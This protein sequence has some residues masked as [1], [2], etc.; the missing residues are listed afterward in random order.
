[1]AMTL[2]IH[3]IEAMCLIVDDFT[4]MADSLSVEESV[5][6]KHAFS[7][8]KGKVELALSMMTQQAIATLEG[9]PKEIDGVVYVPHDTGKWRPDQKRIRYEVSVKSC[10]DPNT[11]EVLEAQ[12]A[13]SRAVDIMYDLFVAP[14][15]KPKDAGLKKLG[16]AMKDVADWEVTGV[17]LREEVA[18]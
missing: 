3:D 12:Q 16:L 17:E 13:A 4:E 5:R 7:L 11:G 10:Y 18:E 9:T 14:K 2:N 8:L 1:M 15:T 6:Y